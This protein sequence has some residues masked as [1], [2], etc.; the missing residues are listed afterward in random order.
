MVGS[1]FLHVRF[2]FV[3]CFA[4]K[5]VLGYSYFI[6]HSLQYAIFTSCIGVVLRHIILYCNTGWCVKEGPMH[7]SCQQ[8]LGSVQGLVIQLRLGLGLGPGNGIIPSFYFSLLK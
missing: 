1:F 6:Y 2:F 3:T 5:H 4:H 8:W 7:R